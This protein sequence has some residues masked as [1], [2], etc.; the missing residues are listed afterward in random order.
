MTAGQLIL[1]EELQRAVGRDPDEVWEHLYA[2]ASRARVNNAELDSLMALRHDSSVVEARRARLERQA[3]KDQRWLLDNNVLSP[4]AEAALRVRIAATAAGNTR[5][6]GDD[7]DEAPDP[8]AL[9]YQIP[10]AGPAFDPPAAPMADF[11]AEVRQDLVMAIRPLGRQPHRFENSGNLC[12]RN[13]VLTALLG[14]TRF[15]AFLLAHARR[16]R[17]VLNKPDVSHHL[18]TRLYHLAAAYWDRTGVHPMAATATETY[19]R[20][21][22]LFWRACRFKTTRVRYTDTD[23]GPTPEQLDNWQTQCLTQLE[24]EGVAVCNIK[25]PCGI[26]QD[27]VEFLEWLVS[28][29]GAQ[30]L[31]APDRY[32]G[33]R[34]AEYFD[35]MFHTRLTKR[36]VCGHCQRPVRLRKATVE[37]NTV[38]RVMA[39][40]QD[41]VPF[42]KLFNAAFERNAEATC[43][44]CNSKNS[45]LISERMQTTPELLP[46]QIQR[47]GNSGNKRHTVV[48]FGEFL[49]VSPWLEPHIYAEGTRIIYRLAAVVSHQSDNARSGHY[50][51]YV[52]TSPGSAGA[53]AAFEPVAEYSTAHRIMSRVQSTAARVK[54]DSRAARDRVGASTS[55]KSSDIRAIEALNA[56]WSR[57]NDGKGAAQPNIPFTRI[58]NTSL[59]PMYNKNRDEWF[60]PVLLIYEKWIEK[61]VRDSITNRR[62]YR[63]PMNS[64]TRPAFDLR[65]NAERSLDPHANEPNDR[66]TNIAEKDHPALD[67]WPPRRQT[68]PPFG[69]YASERTGDEAVTD[70]GGVRAVVNDD[71]GDGLGAVEVAAVNTPPAARPARFRTGAG[72]AAAAAGAFAAGTIAANAIAAVAKMA[73][74]SS[75]AGPMADASRMAGP[76]AD[77]RLLTSVVGGGPKP[78]ARQ[79]LLRLWRWQGPPVE[80]RPPPRVHQ[81]GNPAALRVATGNAAAMQGL[82]GHTTM[83]HGSMRIPAMAG[84]S[85]GNTGRLH[86][87]TLQ[88]SMRST[89]PPMNFS[90]GSPTLQNSTNKGSRAYGAARNPVVDVS[91]PSYLGAFS[92]ALHGVVRPSDDDT[93]E[94]PA[95]RQRRRH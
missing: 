22:T 29:A 2:M 56:G 18:L 62:V 47:V 12:Y 4:N 86:G 53:D 5:A 64:T 80:V 9:P 71:R 51:S 83:L 24:R 10:S 6:N 31:G 58:N 65:P 63:V 75:T 23:S 41:G 81:A 28:Y 57:V 30:L 77:S 21:A 52:R 48:D 15:L 7:G 27:A 33:P 61:F 72:L 8:N 11:L 1:L 66:W 70:R 85:T 95:K 43:E 74:A 34:S 37:T 14:S 90:F 55:R 44:R 17:L 13:A 38:L 60:D 36:K 45:L 94:R 87:M 79:S 73:G 54:R 16:V 25:D 19:E 68:E 40:E 20:M 3:A 76:V 46:V 82:T 92:S 39:G 50:V 49:D 35:T 89:A 32:A 93:E 84:G 67:R 69:T 91:R 26:Q 59:D 78:A 88:E 42:A